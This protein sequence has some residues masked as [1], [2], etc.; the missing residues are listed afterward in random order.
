MLN[1]PTTILLYFGD[2]RPPGK[3]QKEEKY[4]R[5]FGVFLNVEHTFRNKV[6]RFLGHFGGSLWVPGGKLFSVF[7][8]AGFLVKK[9]A[10][11]DEQGRPRT[12]KD[13]LDRPPCVP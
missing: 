10:N 13:D 3:L 12:K 8:R 1:D 6:L 4:M 7:L 9:E 2:L 11:R 5:K